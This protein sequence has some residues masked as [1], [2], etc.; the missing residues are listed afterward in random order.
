[1][2]VDVGREREEGEV[3]VD[4]KV[5]KMGEEGILFLGLVSIPADAF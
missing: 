5:R 2:C 3:E 1:M 4:M